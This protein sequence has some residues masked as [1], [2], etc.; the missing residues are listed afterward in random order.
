MVFDAVHPEHIPCPLNDA[1]SL[2]NIKN[3]IMKGCIRNCERS[4]AIQVHVC[5]WS[6]ASLRSSQ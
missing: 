2:N 1:I 5:V 4:E 3:T 6:A